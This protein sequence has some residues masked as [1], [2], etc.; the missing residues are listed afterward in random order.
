MQTITYKNVCTL[1]LLFA[2][3]N[4]IYAIYHDRI[5]KFLKLTAAHHPD[6]E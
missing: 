4:Q 3:K 1:S 6:L 2:Q 5:S